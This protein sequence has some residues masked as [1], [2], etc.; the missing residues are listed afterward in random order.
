MNMLHWC[1]RDI[2]YVGPIPNILSE[3]R[4]R[5]VLQVFAQIALTTAK[6]RYLV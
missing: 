6:H 5:D 3:S 4:Q 1:N 2:I